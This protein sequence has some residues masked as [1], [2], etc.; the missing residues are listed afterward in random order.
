M[1][2]PWLVGIGSKIGVAA[3]KMHL[4]F[5][6]YAV[7]NTIFQQFCG[8]TTL[9]ESQKSIDKLYEYNVLTILDYG[10]EHKESEQDFNKVMNETIRAI[11]FAGSN[12]SVPVVSSKITGLARF[13]LMESI[14]NGVPLTKETRYE[15][16]NVLKRLDAISNTASVNGVGV[17]YDAEESWIQDTIDHMV[18]VM[19]ERYNKERVV[20]Y[21]TY[22]LYRTERLQYLMDSFSV[23][24]KEGFLL[25]AKLVR[26][27]YLE[28][29]RERA[30]H[31]GY[32]SPVFDTKE[33][34]DDAYNT[35]V[36]FCVDNYE[37]VYLINASHNAE[38]NLLQ[39]ELMIEK[40]IP[41]NHPHLSFSQLLGMSDNLT[42]NLANAGFN[43]SK[44]VPYGK[45]KE[46]VPYLIRRAQ[47]NSAVTG[48]M[49]REYKMV[50]NELK[51]RRLA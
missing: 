50:L 39:A 14:Q 8:G 38:S 28:K 25:G 4:P 22:Q 45:V 13:E 11:E 2:K 32:P 44:Y 9:L 7:K 47:E 43:V 31:K 37:K 27:A 40:N 34:T 1:N 10:A 41:K 16:R 33:E 19:M 20:V 48:D 26:G 35:S 24:E 30:M 29:E 42:F 18:N 17:S 5:I 12:K 23:A 3:I 46:V 49:S 36:R 21:N 6:E 15:Y 51:R